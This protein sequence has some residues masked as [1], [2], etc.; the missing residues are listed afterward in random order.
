MDAVWQQ[1]VEPPE[2]DSPRSPDQ[3][4]FVAPDT[5][6][7]FRMTGQ[8][9]P[10]PT[11]R[12]AAMLAALAAAPRAPNVVNA[13][14][15]DRWL[16]DLAAAFAFLDQLTIDAPDTW[17]IQRPHRA[18]GGVRMALWDNR[19]PLAATAMSLVAAV[20]FQQTLDHRR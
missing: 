6:G 17:Y 11:W 4:G 5:V 13:D 1:Q 15:R 10:E 2:A 9:V 18:I 14:Q 12:S 8:L 3:P 7:G 16:V 19:L 20:E